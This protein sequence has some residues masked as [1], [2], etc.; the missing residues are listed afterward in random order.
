MCNAPLPISKDGILKDA[1]RLQAQL[2]APIESRQRIP[3]DAGM[4]RRGISIA[5]ESLNAIFLVRRRRARLGVNLI[6][7]L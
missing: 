1:L 2:L 4:E 7:D 3:I 6:D 5:P